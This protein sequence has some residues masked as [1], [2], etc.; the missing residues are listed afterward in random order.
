MIADVIANYSRYRSL[1][2]EI[3]KALELCGGNVAEAAKKLQ[4]SQATLYRKIQK[5][6]L[7]R[8]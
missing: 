4:L 6:G 1:G 2:A 5:Y 3:E 8:K 7:G